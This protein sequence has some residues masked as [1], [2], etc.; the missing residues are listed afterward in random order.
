MGAIFILLLI[1]V[2]SNVLL[3]EQG[4]VTLTGIL[5][6]AQNVLDG[7]GFYLGIEPGESR[8][9]STYPIGYPGLIVIIAFAT[10]LKV[11]WASK[12]L[13]LLLAGGLLFSFYRQFREHAWI[14]GMILLWA[15]FLEIFSFTWTEGA[16][17]FGLWGFIHFSSRYIKNNGNTY[18][19]L[20]FIGS[21]ILFVFLMRYI[22]AFTFIVVGIYLLHGWIKNGRLDLRLTFTTFLV[23]L[24][25]IGYLYNNYL[26]E[27]V[28]TGIE[29]TPN[30]QSFPVL[31]LK[32]SKAF[33]KELTIPL[34]TKFSWLS[35]VTGM[36]F[37]QLIIILFL[38]RKLEA[39]KKPTLTIKKPLYW[40]MALLTGLIYLFAFSFIRFNVA[41][42]DFNYRYLCPFTFL[43]AIGLLDYFQHQNPQ[44]FRISGKFLLI[45][46]LGSWLLNVP[47]KHLYNQFLETKPQQTYFQHNQMIAEKYDFVKDTPTLIVF[48]D[49]KLNYQKPQVATTS[50]LTIA[51]SPQYAL[52]LDSFLIDIKQFKGEV[53]W[54]IIDPSNFSGPFK[55]HPSILKFMENHQDK[56]FIRVK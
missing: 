21:S 50:P 15:T 27:G 17:L 8:L 51:S 39:W 13:N 36:F 16:F 28:I 44:W 32:F 43:V 10:G 33:L 42:D 53:Y 30:V 31:L 29:R 34:V 38:S 56:E 46:G 14:F 12:V 24:I 7:K 55:Y 47:V 26:Q 6:V 37:L 20:C 19:N 23:G 49:Q 48:G 18:L 45:F 4:K 40:K 1:A 2:L 22:G 54:E 52:P 35:I 3:A 41:L 25:C 9:Y 11:F 5:E